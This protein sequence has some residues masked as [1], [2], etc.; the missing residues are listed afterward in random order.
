MV[1]KGKLQLGKTNYLNEVIL[2][3][4]I[5]GKPGLKKLPSGDKLVQFRL[6]VDRKL[7]N[8]KDRG[9]NTVNKK[10]K[11]EVDTL[12]IGVWRKNLQPRALTLVP[13]QFV[14]VSGAIRRNFWTTPTGLASRYQ[15]D[16]D[17]IQKL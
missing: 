12:D 7:N 8:H 1:E 16:A 5:S 2:Q 14:K 10:R 3:G 13:E 9:V 17:Q 11:R 6:V 15:I 4:R